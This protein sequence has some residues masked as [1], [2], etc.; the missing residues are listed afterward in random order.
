MRRLGHASPAAANR[1]LHTVDGRDAGIASA[2]TAGPA[3]TL[4]V[5]CRGARTRAR[6]CTLTVT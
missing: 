4:T 2:S 5:E 1:Y 3:G 6:I